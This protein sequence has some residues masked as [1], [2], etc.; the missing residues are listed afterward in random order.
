MT[1]PY[2]YLNPLPEPKLFES[3]IVVH[4]NMIIDP[5]DREYLNDLYG[6]MEQY[7]TV[8]SI[9][10]YAIETDQTMVRINVAIKSEYEFL[11]DRLNKLKAFI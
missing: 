3:R 11:R 7:L 6:S 10:I 8:I 2:P 5:F 9:E 1:M 4:E